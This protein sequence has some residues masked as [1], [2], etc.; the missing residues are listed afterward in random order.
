MWQ[1]RHLVFVPIGQASRDDARFLLAWPHL[2]EPD[3]PPAGVA[4][5]MWAEPYDRRRLR[6]PNEPA[7]P[8]D[9]VERFDEE[10]RI[11]WLQAWAAGET[12]R[13]R[14]TFHIYELQ[15]YALRCVMRFLT[16]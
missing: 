2:I 9:V 11:E 3:D 12:K 8:K 13:A 1:D 14:R 15:A 7:P 5:E 4:P 16:A 6:F 10:L